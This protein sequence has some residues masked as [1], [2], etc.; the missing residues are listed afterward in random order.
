MIRGS[1]NLARCM[2]KHNK[3]SGIRYSLWQTKRELLIIPESKAREYLIA[4]SL[5]N[6]ESW[7]NHK[8]GEL[9]Q[10]G[11]YLIVTCFE[12][13]A[14]VAWIILNMNRTLR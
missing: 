14:N 2:L 4:N 1:Q 5:K 10:N 13:W 7:S 9:E 6:S 8:N 12:P 3:H 11:A